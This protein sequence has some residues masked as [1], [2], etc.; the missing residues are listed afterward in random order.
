M[1]GHRLLIDR[2]AHCHVERSF[3]IQKKKRQQSKVNQQLLVFMLMPLL[4]GMN[5]GDWSADLLDSATDA[6]N[7]ESVAFWIGK[8]VAEAL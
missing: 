4:C 7:D 3:S 8:I 1:S 5:R 2:P 6:R